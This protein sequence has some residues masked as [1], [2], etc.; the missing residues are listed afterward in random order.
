MPSPLSR[1][2][3]GLLL[4]AGLLVTAFFVILA[5]YLLLAKGEENNSDIS[6]IA[7]PAVESS[8]GGKGT[9]KYNS[10]VEEENRQKAQTAREEG[11]SHVDIPTGQELTPKSPPQSPLVRASTSPEP[12]ALSVPESGAIS[13]AGPKASVPQAPIRPKA[14]KESRTPSETGPDRLILAALKEIRGANLSFGS[15]VVI[16]L[17]AGEDNEATIGASNALG[18]IEALGLKA[19]D[20]LYGVITIAVNSDIPSPVM[21]EIVEGSFRGSKCLGGFKLVGEEVILSFTKLISPQ[22]RQYIIEAVGVNPDTSLAS[23]K[24][25]VD[26][27][28]FQR[29][30]SL[31][32]ASFLEG[33]GAAAGSRSTRVYVDGDRVIE[34]GSLKTFEDM[35]LEALGKVGSR[36]ANQVEAGFARPPT[37]TVKAGQELGILILNIDS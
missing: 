7:A 27:H 29:W 1:V 17:R 31:I 16:A 33:I 36:A 13:P 26:T 18:D 21:A 30:G 3:R 34:D 10:L 4:F 20:I 19:G 5:V 12:A 32:A 8:V 2:P 24:S 9:P 37:V 6:L 15:P 28:F 25:H 23:V 35:T 22:G 11:T 14:E